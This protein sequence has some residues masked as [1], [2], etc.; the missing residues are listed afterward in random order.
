MEEDENKEEAASAGSEPEAAP[1]QD[2][3]ADSGGGSGSDPSADSSSDSGTEAEPNADPAS[4]PDANSEDRAADGAEA[5]ADAGDDGGQSEILEQ[6][7]IDSL[8]QQF[9]GDDSPEGEADESP[10]TAGAEATPGIIFAYGQKPGTPVQIEPYDFRNPAF[11]GEMEMRR[12]RLMHEDFI[13]F[14]EARITLYMRSDFS[15]KMTHLSTKSYEQTVAEVENPTHL[16]LFRVPPMPGVGYIE[17][18]PNLALTIASSIL[19]GKGHAPR[20]ERYL[21]QIEVDLIEEFLVMVLDEWASRWESEEKEFEPEIIG[22]EIVANVLQICEHDTVMFS[23]MMDA[24]LR[25]ANGRIG[26]CVP[27]HMIEEPIRHLHLRRGQNEEKKERKSRT[28]RPMYAEIPVAGEAVFPLG[29]YSV[30]EVMQWK[31]GTVIPFDEAVLDDV[32]LKLADIPLFQGK[33]GVDNENR[34]VQ[35]KGR[36]KKEESIWQMKN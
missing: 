9:A 13:R 30:E 27:L 4:E 19:G 31:E 18:S 17:M 24:S 22:H 16:A 28:W 34:A 32:T 14:L 2:D 26:I 15:L 6:D 10:V 3:V 33:A 35:I 25:G 36:S 8:L 12:L 1:E 21:T 29:S 5:S 23:L 11:L 20:I 7:D